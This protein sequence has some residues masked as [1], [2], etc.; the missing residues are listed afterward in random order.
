MN[1]TL[2]QKQPKFQKIRKKYILTFFFLSFVFFSHIHIYIYIYIYIYDVEK[3]LS[4]SNGNNTLAA[5]IDF[6]P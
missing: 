2:N 4:I 6:I 3:D 5:I 1:K